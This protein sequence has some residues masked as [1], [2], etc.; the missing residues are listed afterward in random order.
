MGKVESAIQKDIIAYLRGL[1]DTYVLNIGGSASTAKGT[2]DL[3]VC[4]KS[5]F[6]AFEIKRPD[7]SYGLT[8]P[9][10]IRMGQIANAGGKS[11]MVKSV[12]DVIAALYPK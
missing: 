7:S 3:I 12:G 5:R 4:H 2:P 11:A 1:D 8:K 9:Q 6:Y 10:Q